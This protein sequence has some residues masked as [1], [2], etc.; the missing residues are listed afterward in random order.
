[1]WAW[2]VIPVITIIAL[3]LTNKF[4]RIAVLLSIILGGSLGIL[5]T[6]T[7]SVLFYTTNCW[8]AS[9]KTYPL[10]AYVFGMRY[11]ERNGGYRSF[12]LSK[13][14]VNMKFINSKEFFC[15]DNKKMFTFV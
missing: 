14:N 2:Y 5:V 15:L 9:S 11:I 10:D 8:F 7:L 6:G 13:Y 4:K 1:M 12:S 3:L